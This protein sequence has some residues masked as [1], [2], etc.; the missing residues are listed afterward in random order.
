[1][2]ER[3]AHTGAQ[4]APDS[5][6][7]SDASAIHDQ[8]VAERLF[9]MVSDLAMVVGSD[10]RLVLTNPAWADT[11]GWRKEDLTGR[12]L[13][14]LVHP[15]DVATTFELSRHDETVVDFTNRLLHRNGTWR[16]VQWSGR[17]QAGRWYAVGKD[18]TERRSREREALHDELTGLANRALLLDHLRS[19]L[20]RLAR[21]TGHVLA[22][23]F[24]DLDG[25]KQIN[26]AF[27]HETGDQ[28]LAA[29]AERLRNTVR[30]SD[31][32]ARFG[33]DEFVVIA[34][35]LV[36]EGE[37]VHL[38]ERIVEAVH[39]EFDLAA[40]RSAVSCSVGIST[41][42]DATVDP[43]TLLREADV[44]MYLAKGRGPGHVEL[45]DTHIRDEMAGRVRIERELRAA[46]RGGEI[47]LAFQ[48]IVSVADAT[49]VG[50]EALVR[51]R[52][53]T[54]G[55]LRPA[56]FVP[57]AEAGG[58]IVPLG[59][60]V[61][62]L[63]C[64]QA[65]IWRKQGQS[66][67]VSVNVSRRQLLEPGFPE[68]VRATLSDA[69]IPGE[70]LCLEL[71]ETSAP[72]RHP[73]I[74]EALEEIRALGMRIALDDF[75]AGYSS[76]ANLKELPVDLIKIDRTFVAALTTQNGAGRALVAAV[77]ALARELDL[78]VVAE[79]VEDERQ[80]GALRSLGCQF[81]QGHLFGAATPADRVPMSGYSKRLFPGMAD[82]S[83]I[84]EF[85]R[86]IGIPARMVR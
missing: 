54:E 47:E 48:P 22:A 49:L 77:M 21:D 31:M 74:V 39:G 8:V 62:E 34:E 79:G 60:R 64:A 56:R 51:W 69:G 83:E 45:F 4:D 11:L 66:V 43:D 35:G 25:F 36:A 19:A 33:G 57:L 80:L 10:G 18:V 20:A 3:R 52:H 41:T 40:G 16:W 23:L 55:V 15:D 63:A 12:S 42:G 24:I 59:R 86:Q 70:M 29:V 46:L 27:G 67:T 1:M 37:A 7:L 13:L 50:A 65:A 17:A 6:E 76:L 32:L 72:A 78:P 85:M 14:E 28:L 58:L 30:D 53:P 73:L 9:A 44:A 81:A 38:A 5:A 84:L 61:L 71:T 75:G 26:D 68:V 2:I 82:S